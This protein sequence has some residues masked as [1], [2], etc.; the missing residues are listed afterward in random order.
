MQSLKTGSTIF[1]A[2]KGAGLATMTFW[3]WRAN[4]PRLDNLINK[5]IEGRIQMVE[6]ALFKNA[7]VHDN[8]TA[9]IFYLKNRGKDWKDTPFIDASR[10][11]HL[12]FIKEALKKAEDVDIHGR[13]KS[14]INSGKG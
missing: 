3:R 6:D 1:S 12:T 9:Q 14:A 5:I 13:I 7:V 8:V 10:H 11:T 4:N 2:C